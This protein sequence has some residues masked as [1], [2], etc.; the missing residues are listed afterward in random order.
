MPHVQ[1]AAIKRNGE[2]CNGFAVAGGEF[3]FCHS[4][5]ERWKAAN[6]AGGAAA[7]EADT[8]RK[9]AEVQLAL[10]T[11]DVSGAVSLETVEGVRRLLAEA[12]TLTRNGWMDPKVSNALSVLAN[13]MRSYLELSNI[14]ERLTALE[15]SLQGR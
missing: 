6:A 14:E 5:P 10:A 1:C 9:R 3:C 2:Q 13:S 11:G 7:R 4:D 12:L 8:E 15:S